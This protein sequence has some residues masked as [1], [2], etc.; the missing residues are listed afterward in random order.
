MSISKS[1]LLANT[2]NAIYILI[3]IGII[4]LIIIGTILYYLINTIIDPLNQLTDTVTEF[5]KQNFSKRSTIATN[6]EIGELAQNFNSMANSIQEY[7]NDMEKKI[8]KEQ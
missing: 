4:S 2:L 7:S 5:G 8:Q 1:D 6:D 3:C